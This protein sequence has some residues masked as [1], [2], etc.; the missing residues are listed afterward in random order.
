M[1]GTVFVAALAAVI[2]FGGSA[3]ATKIAVSAIS[4]IDVSI[5]RTVIGALIAIP[6]AVTLRISL[7]TPH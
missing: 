2:I 3:V 6:M 7:P 4:A 1:N 5:L